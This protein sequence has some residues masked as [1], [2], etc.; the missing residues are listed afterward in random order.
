M[1]SSKRLHFLGD[2]SYGF[3]TSKKPTFL[4]TVENNLDT[5]CTCFQV[6]LSSG[7]SYAP[8]VFDFEDVI[9]TRKI[10]RKS[11]RAMFIHGCLLYNLAG[12]AKGKDTPEFFSGLSKTVGALKVELDLC[13]ALGGRG[14]VVHPNSYPDVEEG[15]KIVSETCARVLTEDS[16]ATKK[17]CTLLGWTPKKLKS[18]RMLLLE[19]CAG[20]G[21]KLGKNL[22][23][24][25]DMIS[26]TLKINHRVEK[27]IGVCID[28]AHAYGA[29]VFDFGKEVDI[30]RF[31]KEFNKKIGLDKLKLF[32][33]NDSKKRIFG[34]MSKAR[35]GY[36][37]SK[38]DMHENLGLGYIFD[39]EE[40][41]C[42]LDVFFKQAKKYNVSIIGEPPGPGSIDWEVC[43]H[44]VSGLCE[45]VNVS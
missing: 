37:G 36:F 23:E 33:L 38:K 31:Y 44:Y 42:T 25:S 19:N 40:R 6:Y 27:R 28:T 35:D 39:T 4:E 12:S 32:H 24:L 8:P 15:I 43:R 16:V 41:L 22:D 14:V 11:K 1:C 45:V 18:R 3:H 9:K 7:R 10:L 30:F 5:P 26:E 34:T 13:A 29:G 20:E 2:F 17:L 21:K